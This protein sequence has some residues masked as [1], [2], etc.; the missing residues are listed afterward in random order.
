VGGSAG[1]L[2]FVEIGKYQ[3]AHEISSY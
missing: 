1:E 2:A 3:N